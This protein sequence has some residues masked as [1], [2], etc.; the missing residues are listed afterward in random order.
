MARVGLAREAVGSLAIAGVLAL[1]AFVLPA[2]DRQIPSERPVP[3]AMPYAVGGS[4]TVV[5]PAGASVELTQTRPG[6]ERG[7][8]LFLVGDL[9]LAVVVG[10]FRGGLA[11]AEERL[12]R[13][14]ES[15]GSTPGAAGQEVRT[16]QGV[17]GRHGTYTSPGRHGEYAVFLRDSEMV[18]ATASGPAD[19]YPTLAPR[20]REWLRSITFGGSR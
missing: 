18:Q 14:I 8:A 12:R 1:F 7:S 19:A 6:A 17:V 5:P 2:V 16:E 3:P 9:R 4:V 11:E 15:T 20:V 13:R 10:P